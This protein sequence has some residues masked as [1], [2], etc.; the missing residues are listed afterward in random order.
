VKSLSPH[1]SPTTPK[2][3]RRFVEQELRLATGGRAE[4]AH[5]DLS[6]SAVFVERHAIEDNREHSTTGRRRA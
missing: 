6:P 1:V 3:Q 2:R 5:H 4:R